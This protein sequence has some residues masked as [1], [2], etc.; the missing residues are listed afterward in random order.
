MNH[1]G[2]LLLN[3][4][5]EMFAQLT[6]E[7]LHDFNVFFLSEAYSITLSRMLAWPSVSIIRLPWINTKESKRITSAKTC[8]LIYVI[9]HFFTWSLADEQSRWDRIGHAK[10]SAIAKCSLWSSE[11]VSIVSSQVQFPSNSAISLPTLK[12]FRFARMNMS[13]YGH[14]LFERFKRRSPFQKSTV[15]S[16]Q[17]N[18]VSDNDY[19]GCCHGEDVIHMSQG[20]TTES[21]DQVSTSRL[22]L[23]ELF[24]SNVTM[25]CR[26]DQLK[27]RR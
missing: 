22:S 9:E 10:S 25:P 21:D 23:P 5:T 27:P 8:C 3:H 19:Q 20:E 26:I 1:E 24:V 11:N 15:V 17:E 2:K 4:V 16:H 18:V 14:G 6:W 12:H 13:E 7:T